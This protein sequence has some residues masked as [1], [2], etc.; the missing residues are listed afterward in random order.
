MYA[1]PASG[2]DKLNFIVTGAVTPPFLHHRG[3]LGAEGEE[4]VAHSLSQ[5]CPVIL[6]LSVQDLAG[7]SHRVGKNS[8]DTSIVE[9]ATRS[10]T[11]TRTT[12]A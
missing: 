6:H 4:G 8:P 2:S 10:C 3:A 12:V 11:L 1:L 7:D 9:Y 5:T